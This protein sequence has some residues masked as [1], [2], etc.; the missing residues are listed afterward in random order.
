MKHPAHLLLALALAFSGEVQAQFAQLPPAEARCLVLPLSLAERAAVA[1][2]VVEAEVLSARSFWD[3]G[4]RRIYTAHQLRVFSALKGTAPTQLTVLTEGGTV[5]LDRHQLTNTLELRPGQQGVLFLVPASFADTAAEAGA[6]AVYGSEQ[7]FL[8]YDLATATVADLFRPLGAIDEAFYQQ[9]TEATGQARQLVQP[10]AALTAVRQRLAA[11]V[12]ARGQAPVVS[13]L[14]PATVP[15][16]TGA[17]LT[18]AGSGFGATRG[19]GFVEFPNA[20]N[21]GASLVK[22]QDADYVSWTDTRIVVRVPAL[23]QP[24]A[25]AGSGPVRVTTN[26]QQ[27]ATSATS[28]TVPYA[29]SNVL[30]TPG[31]QLVR[32]N[33][34]SQ[35][36]RGGYSFRFETTFAANTAAT[37]A[38]NRALAT[39]R[40]QTGINW[41]ADAPPRTSRG[42]AEDGENSIG[43][44]QG[45]ELPANVL[46]R[47]TSYYRGC[48]R[49]DGRLVFYV[50]EIDMQF[51]DATTWQFGPAPAVGTQLDFESVVVHEL[52][53]AQQ[54]SHVIL[55]RAIMHFAVA[56]GQ[57]TRFL[58]ADDVA[59]GRVVLRKRSFA[60]Q[61]CGPAPMLPAPLTAF[62]AAPSSAGIV[63]SW[64]TRAECFLSGFEVQRAQGTDTTAWQTL[65]AV[66]VS[67][68]Y[69][70]LDAQPQAG[71]RYYRLRLRRPDGSFDATAPV[72]VS[73]DA[74][75]GSQPSVFPNP[76][77]G[78]PLQ[79]YYP[80]TTAGRLRAELFDA[81]GRRVSTTFLEYQPGLNLLPVPTETLKAGWYVLRYLDTDSRTGALRFVKTG[82]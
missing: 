5:G 45:G 42:A 73:A 50:Q 56:R 27:Q 3:A 41:D 15:A 67:A 2:L 69:T 12:V 28:L 39:W 78:Q 54:L 35:N 25:P 20:D 30:S 75:A 8:P 43:F 49:P 14:S 7:G 82:E 72:L 13:S 51:D 58:A 71:L 60:V 44:D 34:I 21:G 52:G 26:D 66:P 1:P 6:W 23:G 64:A 47:T 74:A 17:V 36:G 55:P 16:G 32:P 53:H 63:L 61:G 22:P 4:H 37:A 24:A 33:H 48:F 79:L 76:T 46:G 59:G 65:A 31:N 68:A 38:W 10:N 9:L 81:V 62:S 80:A 18:L 70:Y 40:C 57:N 77:A 29:V 19:V 11:P